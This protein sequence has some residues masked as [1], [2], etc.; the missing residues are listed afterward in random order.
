M[1]NFLFHQYFSRFSGKFL[2]VCLFL[3]QADQ[4]PTMCKMP[5]MVPAKKLPSQVRHQ[6]QGQD[7]HARRLQDPQGHGAASSQEW[8]SRPVKDLENIEQPVDLKKPREVKEE[9]KVDF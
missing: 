3:D 6:D 9:I 2:P 8:E 1:F 7:F 4:K 5:E